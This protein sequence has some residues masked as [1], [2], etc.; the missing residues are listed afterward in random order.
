MGKG[1]NTHFELNNIC[2]ASTNHLPQPA[3]VTMT[4]GSSVQNSDTL[5]SNLSI[6][7]LEDAYLIKILIISL[8]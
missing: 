8:L 1:P 2:L 3:Q 5:F 6:C 4:P 7:S